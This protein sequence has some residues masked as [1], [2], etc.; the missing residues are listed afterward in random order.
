MDAKRFI[1]MLLLLVGVILLVALYSRQD[2]PA[3]DVDPNAEAQIG[4]Q[5]PGPPPAEV[6]EASPSQPAISAITEGPADVADEDSIEALPALADAADERPVD[7]PPAPTDEPA[8][9]SAQS[10]SPAD[11]E[12]V[13]TWRGTRVAQEQ[14][15]TIGSLAPGIDNEFKLMCRLTNIGAAVAVVELT[16]HFITVD[17]KQ[18]YADSVDDPAAY[19]RAR[20]AEPDK[21]RGHYRLGEPVT[22]ND[23]PVGAFSVGEVT[24][25]I[26]GID[27]P[28]APITVELSGKKWQLVEPAE[29]DDLNSVTFSYTL[30]YGP[31]SAPADAVLRIYKTYTIAPNDYAIGMAI[32]LANLSAY[33]LDVSLDQI[34]PTGLP[35]E[36]VRGDGRRGAYGWFVAEDQTVDVKLENRKLLTGKGSIPLNR[37]R[38]LRTEKGEPV[39]WVGTT[40]KY[41]ATLMYVHPDESVAGY[42]EGSLDI[43]SWHGEFYLQAVERDDDRA[44]L[45]GVKIGAKKPI[46]L[47]AGEEKTIN[48]T[49]FAGPKG[50]GI[51][52]DPKNP[53]FKPLYGQ[54]DFLST[55]EFG[56]CFCTLTWLAMQV[57]W[58]LGVI[59]GVVGNNYGVAIIILVVIV[60]ALLH[61]LTKKSQVSM[62]KMQKLQPQIKK[63]REKYA[64]DK[65]TLNK[66]MMRIYKEQGTTPLL[67]CLPMLLQ[68]PILIALFTGI[69]AS[70]ALRHAAFLPVWITDLAAPD[71]LITW[72]QPLPLIGTSFNLLPVL[73]CLVMFVQTKM[74]PQMSGQQAGSSEQAAQQAKMMKIMMPAMMLVFFY[75]AASGLT[76]YFM[77]STAAG[78]V[79]QWAVRR[80]IRQQEEVQAATETTIDMPGKAA[81]GHRPKKPKEPYQ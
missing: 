56:G 74:N 11:Q 43:S 57:L 58:L 66:E 76:L 23:R 24:V 51:F 63:L 7:T 52:V 67:G 69:N 28:P 41:F 37:T 12:R 21:Y 44:F 13:I 26:V 60:R 20:Q 19:E 65:D 10:V 29:G 3:P 54:L 79:D 50:R 61:P 39:V 68:M 77:A 35:R 81:R 64:D 8:A 9:P 45:A 38:A 1:P 17:D 18:L 32:S 46:S 5:E 48:L 73:L 72:Q 15:V 80:H 40:N 31:G 27:N 14:E 62:M 34:G 53:L 59:A 47:P 25:R 49:V 55:I 71:A 4:S 70:V 16:D 42:T 75:K 30:F 36:D 33:Q 2:S 6:A 22:V 78:L